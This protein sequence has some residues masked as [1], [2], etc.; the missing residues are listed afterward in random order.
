M[1]TLSTLERSDIRTGYERVL[2][3]RGGNRLQGEVEIGGAKNA[4]LKAMAAALLTSD[5]VV[6]NNIPM[7]ADVVSMCALLR[8]LGA[9]VDLD[10][11]RKRVV[12]RA[13]EIAR[14]NAPPELFNATRA[15]VVV[16]GPLLSRC[17]E[18]SFFMPGG[19]DIG[20]RPIDM[21]LRGFERLGAVVTH[22]PGGMIEAKGAPLRGSRIYMDYPSHTGTETLLMASTLASGQTVIANASAEPEVVWLGHMLNRMGARISGLGSPI[23]TVEGVD[24]LHAVSDVVIPDRLEAGT[25]A[26]AAV[27]TGGEITLRNSREP[28]MMPISEKLMEAGAQV[29]HRPGEML[30]RAGKSLRAVDIQTLPF[31][32]FPTDQQAPFLAMLTQAEGVSIVHERVYEDRLRYTDDL[33]KMG[34][35]IQI[36]RFGPQNE[37]LATSAKVTGPRRLTGA[38]V[39]ALDI[40]SAVGLVLAGL[41]A[42]GE[43]VMNE[44]YHVE[45]GYENF[46][47]KL[48]SLGADIEEDTMLVASGT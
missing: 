14:T 6:L 38:R 23:I 2:R 11:T 10:S 26:I 4:A 9:E 39:T 35:D 48:R 31:P 19:D 25:F 15:S 27:M 45:R 40:R 32:G 29:W 5:D 46:V 34:A 13:R 16:A 1:T 41:V 42:D 22:D 37:Y 30:I 20:R 44:V 8:A 17:G 3:I 47:L 21:H 43:T 33:V 12:I 24:R 28:H 36:D 18:V 7:L